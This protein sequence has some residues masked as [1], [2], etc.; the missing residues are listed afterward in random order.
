[1]TD[2]SGDSPRVDLTKQ[3]QPASPPPI[4]TTPLASP[5]AGPRHGGSVRGSSGSRR[6]LWVLAGVLAVVLIGGVSTAALLARGGDPAATPSSL[7]SLGSGDDTIVPDDEQDPGTT[8]DEATTEPTDEPSAEAVESPESVDVDADAASELD[9]IVAS[10]SSAS[11]ALE[12]VWTAQL[13]SSAPGESPAQILNKYHDL[14]AQYPGALLIWSGDWPG[15]FGPSSLESWVVLSGEEYDT[16]RPL[17]EWCASEGW[18]DG[19]CWAKRLATSGDDPL[20]NTDRSPA[21]DRN[22]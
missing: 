6:G 20:L 2:F 15:S 7:S 22:N 3:R 13:A 11:S 8:T 4:P 5:P 12:G 14:K 17:L 10:D 18:S 19:Q 9:A 1:M 21:D 16:T